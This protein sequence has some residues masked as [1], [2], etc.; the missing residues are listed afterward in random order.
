M[1]V[2]IHRLRERLGAVSPPWPVL[3]AAGVAAVALALASGATTAEA[4]GPGATLPAPAAN[5]VALLSRTAGTAASLLPVHGLLGAPTGVLAH[6]VVRPAVALVTSTVTKAT[7][8]P[9]VSKLVE[10]ATR[11]VT[12]T[13]NPPGQSDPPRASVGTQA[14]AHTTSVTPAPSAVSV[15]VA[16]QGAT[17]SLSNLLGITPTATPGPPVP[18]SPAPLVTTPSAAAGP[19]APGG[20]AT[21]IA[22]GLWML[23]ALAGVRPRPPGPIQQVELS[24]PVERPG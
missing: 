8:N 5:A 11:V 21:G 3:V 10:P 24:S 9:T 22:A 19:L 15:A 17:A 13:L 18:A 14:E 23:L 7:A 12:G 6:Q 16:V 4:A 1:T 20:T 2:E